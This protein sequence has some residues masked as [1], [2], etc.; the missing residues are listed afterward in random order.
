MATVQTL[1]SNMISAAN[2]A[3]SDFRKK[4]SDA[5]FVHYQYGGAPD[6]D[7]EDI[8]GG[9]DD[10]QAPM[11]P[12]RYIL[13]RIRP[14]LDFYRARIPRYARRSFMLKVVGVLLGIGA[15]VLS[16]YN[17]TSWVVLVT[18]LTTALTS[19]MEFSDLQAKTE[20]Y[21]RAANTLTDLL[22]WW[23]ALGEVEKASKAVI[24][25]L[26][27]TTE[28]IVSEEL[29]AWT[30]TGSAKDKEK[31]EEVDEDSENP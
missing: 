27:K 19:W 6:S 26:V 22:D 20:R 9:V 4:H 24:N 10:H 25:H 7:D 16:R 8:D 18:A 14:M 17:F 28:E 30:S 23:A 1:R 2:L 21:T 13:L 3:S 5:T 12:S 31:E 15:S 29:L 11:Q